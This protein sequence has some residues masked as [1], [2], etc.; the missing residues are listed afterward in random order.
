M[1]KLVETLMTFNEF[2]HIIESFGLTIDRTPIDSNSTT[3]YYNNYY[4]CYLIQTKKVNR[5]FL[6]GLTYNCV[7][8]NHINKEDFTKHLNDRIIS[9]KQMI[10]STR[11]Q[12]LSE[13][14]K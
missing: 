6:Y 12:S 9:I 8:L 14:F 3:F 7:T 4:V 1:K 10:I 13:D 5:S 11:K 2:N